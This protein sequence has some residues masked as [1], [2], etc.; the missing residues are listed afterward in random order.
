MTPETFTFIQQF[1]LPLVGL[2]AVAYVLYRTLM[3]TI[4]DLRNQRDTAN[5]RADSLIEGL[6]AQTS[7]TTEL[8]TLVKD[9]FAR[10]GQS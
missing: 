8:T 9:G 10:K 1:G 4:A 7:A 2:V 3:G 6:R 5:V